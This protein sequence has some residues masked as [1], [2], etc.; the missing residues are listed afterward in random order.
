V[1]ESSLDIVKTS[2]G[3]V[4]GDK[5]FV[6]LSRNARFIARPLEGE[7]YP[8]VGQCYAHDYIIGKTISIYKGELEIEKINLI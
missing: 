3:A 4:V 6:L 5:V 8:V 2:S 7:N 1:Q